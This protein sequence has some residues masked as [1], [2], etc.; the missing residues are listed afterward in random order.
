MSAPNLLQPAKMINL[1]LQISEIILLLLMKKLPSDTMVL[2]GIF[3]LLVDQASLFSIISIAKGKEQD[4][5]IEP[6]CKHIRL[7]IR[8]IMANLHNNIYVWAVVWVMPYL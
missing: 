1:E 4:C 7:T 6:S 8:E 3:L 5:I 2:I